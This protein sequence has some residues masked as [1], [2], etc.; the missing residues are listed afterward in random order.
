M[1]NLLT[2]RAFA[3]LGSVLFAGCEPAPT[4]CTPIDT[5]AARA[6]WGVQE[7]CDNPTIRV[8]IAEV[9]G[10]HYGAAPQDGL[11]WGKKWHWVKIDPKAVER[12]VAD[13]TLAH[14]IGHLLGHHH[15]DDRC[16]IMS[17]KKDVSCVRKSLGVRL[18]EEE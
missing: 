14:E 17:P 16:D 7:D 2:F 3:V 13:L 9:D 12:G 4:V 11:S 6:A 18:E 8:Y 1:A 10:G 15:T 5:G